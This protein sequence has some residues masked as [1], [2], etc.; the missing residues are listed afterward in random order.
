VANY[1]LSLTTSAEKELQGLPAKVVAQIAIRVERL[2]SVP[3]PPRCKK[4][5]GGDKEWRIRIG[6]YRVVYEIDDAAKTV[7]VTRIAHRRDVYD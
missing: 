4:L 5:V 7:A 6:D 1:R 2:A 3:R